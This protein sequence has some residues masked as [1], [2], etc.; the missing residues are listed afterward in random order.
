MSTEERSEVTPVS[1]TDLSAERIVDKFALLR[2]RAVQLF[3]GLRDLPQ[4][5]QALWENYFR[6]TFDA[7]NSL[8]KFQQEHRVLLEAHGGLR[9]HQ[10]GEV[11]S[12]IGQLYYLFYLRKGDT[13][14]LD[15]AYVFYDFIRRR[16][17]FAAGPNRIAHPGA[18]DGVGP[19]T[20]SSS[21]PSSV[22]PNGGGATSL[23]TDESRQLALRELRY[24]TRFA[25]VCFLTGRRT[26]LN[27]L[28]GELRLKVAEIPNTVD[29]MKA[30][31][32]QAEWEM[33]VGELSEFLRIER[34][35]TIVVL[36][37]GG[38][39][40]IAE[41]V[42]SLALSDEHGT[43]IASAGGG[44][45][46]GGGGGGGGAPAPAGSARA[47]ALR[48][49]SSD[50]P[51]DGAAPQ[52]ASPLPAPTLDE[53]LPLRLQPQLTQPL[54]SIVA[55]MGPLPTAGLSLAQAVLVGAKA[56][57]PKVSELTT[58]L[59]RA[60]HAVEWNAAA[61]RT[62]V[63]AN[64]GPGQRR[65]SGGSDGS[66]GSV[67]PASTSVTPEDDRYAKGD[68]YSTPA[69]GGTTGG[70]L[71]GSGGDGKHGSGGSGGGGVG[72]PSQFATPHKYLLYRPTISNLLLVLGTML[73]ELKENACALVYL[74][75]DGVHAPQAD[76]TARALS[77]SSS[78]SPASS[79][80]APDA[81]A[82]AEPISTAS[83][84]MFSP[85]PTGHATH[86]PL[87]Q[88]SSSS[89]APRALASPATAPMDIT[90][91]PSAAASLPAG[92]SGGVAMAVES[93]SERALRGCALGP[94]DLLPFCRMYAS[95]PAPYPGPINAPAM[96]QDPAPRRAPPSH[97]GFLHC[98]RLRQADGARRRL[99]QRP[100]FHVPP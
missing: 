6:R 11:A 83:L 19:G 97:V 56:G 8:W 75:A 84:T 33:V 61:K 95:P 80:H 15:E 49:E 14:Y 87:L 52:P 9:R 64:H 21:A 91:A 29:P 3:E 81:P 26:A 69:G 40:G 65:P 51:A 79:S 66:G 2:E 37:A 62:F 18:S 39:I 76:A 77:F 10:I 17:Y 59:F 55:G 74:S 47:L 60:L 42:A 23:T 99:G 78:S 16:R 22:H 24:Y 45:S 85:P 28:L 30:V 41:P 44:A 1:S 90:D 50:G 82:T 12:R 93:D 5:G 92:A 13:S 70:A 46:G 32:A 38:R 71:G 48:R 27:E 43:G 57:Q 53:G 36:G 34:S 96:A 35:Y 100:C 68:R 31:R 94:T 20:N 4:Y 58:D 54:A 7:Y 72:S 63:T 86:A 98:A 25:V 88:A 67:A 73:V 89:E